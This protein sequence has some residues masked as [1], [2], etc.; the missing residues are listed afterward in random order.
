LTR[1]AKYSGIDNGRLHENGARWSYAVGMLFTMAA[2]L[3]VFLINGPAAFSAC[4]R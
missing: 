1:I 2:G 3:C 4:R